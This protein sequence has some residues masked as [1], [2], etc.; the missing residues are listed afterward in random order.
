MS[1]YWCLKGHFI[2]SSTPKELRRDYFSFIASWQPMWKAVCHHGHINGPR[3]NPHKNLN[4]WWSGAMCRR[5]YLWRW[6]SQAGRTACRSP[7]PTPPSV[8]CSPRWSR[9]GPQPGRCTPPGSHEPRS[10]QQNTITKGPRNRIPESHVQ[11]PS[12]PHAR[13]IEESQS[14]VWWRECQNS[15]DRLLFLADFKRGSVSL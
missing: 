6:A 10:K 1:L 11:H 5:T 3:V 4:R 13:L 12:K 9:P 15:L 7:Q 14:I 2:L 8:W